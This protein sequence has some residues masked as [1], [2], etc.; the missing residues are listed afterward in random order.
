M[1]FIVPKLDGF[2]VPKRDLPFAQDD[3]CYLHINSDA[4]IASARHPKR[5][6][7]TGTGE[8]P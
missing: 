7:G 3:M 4:K 2:L 8:A 1:N 5:E 6:P